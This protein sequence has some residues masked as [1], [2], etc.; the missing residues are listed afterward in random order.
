MSNNYTFI[1]FLLTELTK[2]ISLILIKPDCYHKVDCFMIFFKLRYYIYLYYE[3]EQFQV[4][5][6]TEQ[7]HVLL[8]KLFHYLPRK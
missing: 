2:I 1:I 8:S 5:N 7:H 6:I 3:T 4:N